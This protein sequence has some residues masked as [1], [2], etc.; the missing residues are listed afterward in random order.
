MTVTAGPCTPMTMSA[1]CPDSAPILAK[2]RRSADPN[3]TDSNGMPFTDYSQVDV[4]CG[5]SNLGNNWVSASIA[6]PS[7]ITCT[8]TCTG[9][10]VA[11]VGGGGGAHGLRPVKECPITQEL[12]IC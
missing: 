11:G 2:F 6:F 9:V 10:C 8:F 7:N 5:R 12:G 3:C 4:I 1:S